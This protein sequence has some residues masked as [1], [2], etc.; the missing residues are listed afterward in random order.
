MQQHVP[1]P[2]MVNIDHVGKHATSEFATSA[3]ITIKRS[4]LWIYWPSTWRYVVIKEQSVR[5]HL[6]LCRL[7]KL[8][9]CRLQS[10]WLIQTSRMKAFWALSFGICVW[11]LCK[12]Q[13]TGSIHSVLDSIY[14]VLRNYVRYHWYYLNKECNY[15]SVLRMLIFS[16]YRTKIK[17]R[18]KL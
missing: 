7:S 15:V 18:I 6:K 17:Q 3:D 16:F 12:N 5:T 13:A 4:K 11:P 2:E 14:T 9:C 8:G 1:S 10:G